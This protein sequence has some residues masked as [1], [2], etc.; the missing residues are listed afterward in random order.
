MV[1]LALPKNSTIEPGRKWNEPGGGRC[2]EFK[3]YRW[4]PD[5]NANPRLDSYWVERGSCG[6]MVLDALIKIKNDIDPTLGSCPR[7]WCRWPV[8]GRAR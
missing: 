2:T 4:H 7:R 8:M 6:P 5:D 1:A 3:I